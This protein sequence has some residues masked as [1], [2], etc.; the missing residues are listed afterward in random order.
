MRD[1]LFLDAIKKIQQK[2]DTYPVEAYFFIRSALDTIIK[3]LDKPATGPGRHVSGQE[4]L[5]GMRLFALQKFG[6]MALTVLNSWNI[7]RTEDFGNLVFNM[8]EI[9]ILGS[10][11]EDTREDFIDG[12]DFDD[13]FR[14]PFLPGSIKAD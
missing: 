7:Y 14:K 3:V 9:G 2:D 13:A 10:T 11:A 1:K 12:Y 6:P 4:L 8:V 5:E